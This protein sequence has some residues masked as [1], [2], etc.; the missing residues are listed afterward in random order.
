MNSKLQM[1]PLV[2][3]LL[4]GLAV[5]AFGADTADNSVILDHH[6]GEPAGSQSAEPERNDAEKNGS[7]HSKTGNFLYYVNDIEY[8][9]NIPQGA[10]LSRGQNVAFR[11]PGGLKALLYRDGNPAPD[12]DLSHITEPGKYRLNVQAAEGLEQ[13]FSFQIVNEITNSLAEIHIP[14]GFQFDYVRL[15]GEE[16]TLAYSNY[17]ELLK[18]GRYDIRYSGKNS[19]KH[20]ELNFLLDRAAPEVELE[21]VV[22]GQAHSEVTIRHLERGN[23]V[24]AECAGETRVI[25]MDGTVL[26]DVGNY[27]LT[28]YD[29]AGNSTSYDFTINFYVNFSAWMA[30]GLVLL[31]SLGLWRYCAYIRRHPKVG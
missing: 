24:E 23:Y 15:D 28:V 20:F 27:R 1:I 17:L 5:P 12:A 9:C 7:Y 14:E 21:G 10:I 11:I 13:T 6:T 25:R 2:A 3:I 26:H 4:L 29:E 30:V 22:N 16:L 18:D 31:V 8:G 19:G